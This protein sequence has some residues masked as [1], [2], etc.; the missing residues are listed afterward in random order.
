[1]P[2]LRNHIKTLALRVDRPSTSSGRTGDVLYS[3]VVSLSNHERIK[4]RP[5]NRVALSV[6]GFLSVLLSVLLWELPSAALAQEDSAQEFQVQ[7]GAYRISLI[8]DPSR[9]SIGTV[10]YT[11]TVVNWGN[12]Q[13]VSDARLRINSRNEADGIGGWAVALHQPSSPG[14][15]EATVQLDGTGTWHTSLE[16]SSSLGQVEVDTPPVTIPEP[17]KTR[18]GSLVFFGVF[19]AILLGVAYLIWSSRKAIKAREAASEN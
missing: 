10:L 12:G 6:L 11:I 9:L 14:T 4:R 1:M 13:P 16:V 15:Y 7:A 18:S 19:L 2:V 8:A 3:F 17:R 5:K